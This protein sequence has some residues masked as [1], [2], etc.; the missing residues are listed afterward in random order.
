MTAHN[1]D[2]RAPLPDFDAG[3][4]SST[5]WKKHLSISDAPQPP[6]P[7]SEE[8]P[9]FARAIRDVTG[10]EDN[11]EL[12]LKAGETIEI[13]NPNI[14]DKWALA[15]KLDADMGLIPHGCYVTIQDFTGTSPSPTSPTFPPSS[16]TTLDGPIRMQSTGE[17][18]IT[19]SLHTLRQ[20]VLGGKSLNRFS[21]F[22]VTGA[23]EWILNGYEPP[24]IT[25]KSHERFRSD[26]TVDGTEEE[27]GRHHVEA[28]MSWREKTPAFNV[29]VHSPEKHSS[30]TGA[31]TLYSITSIF[32]SP[33]PDAEPT[34]ITV[35]RRFSHFNFLHTA[36]SRSL[37][38]IALPPLPAKQYA[39]RFQGEFVEARRGDLEKWLQRIVRH[40]VVRYTEVV[41]FFLGCESDLEWKRL[42]PTYL[43]TLPAG[44]AFYASVFH[45]DFNLDVEDCSSAIDRFEHHVKVFDDRVGTLR[46][47]M[48]G[49]REAR[50]VMAC[51]N[52]ELSLG[53][54][55]VVSEG[56][57]QENGHEKEA[58][59]KEKYLNDEGSWCWKDGCEA[60]MHTTSAVK[61]MAECM[62]GVANLHEDNAKR[63][64]L[65]I[66][67]MVKDISH[68]SMMYAPL[69]D[70]HRQALSRYRDSESTELTINHE[71]SSRCET[72]LHATLAE[73]ETYHTQRAE[74]L[75]RIATEYLDEE[76]G[77]YEQV[78][79]RL[80]AA[81]AGFEQR[82]REVAGWGVSIYEKHLGRPVLP[83]PVPQPTGHVYDSAPV[84]PV[85][86]AVSI[87]M[88][89]IGG[90]A[91]KAG[92]KLWS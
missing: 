21:H 79:V 58:E 53:F 66:H 6:S 27:V 85:S 55:G 51:A 44:P 86:T 74:D 62:Q 54:L 80:R 45:P 65:A 78:L 3:L 92:L 12:G 69:V 14:G 42:L 31:Y 72:V 15:K 39:G 35:H 91:D 70:T 67:D 73:F 76:I 5:A 30:V 82:D 57:K 84:R 37:P 61:K 88:D 13:L 71:T 32:P 16:S 77:L 81:R 8:K 87:L 41:V 28:N 20:S 47:M 50:N 89:G 33:F 49:F 75:T 46:G 29:L 64:T 18:I 1:H 22:V 90:G 17:S 25:S 7:V 19:S 26:V 83:T 34:R 2:L 10:N 9:L 23:E 40:P 38:G 48:G 11:R 52:R 24:P 4:N 68:P 60:C 59:E 63:T 56:P 36:L 43:S